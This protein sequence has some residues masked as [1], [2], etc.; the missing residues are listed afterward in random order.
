MNVTK[1][2]VGIDSTG[3]LGAHNF[4]H[5]RQSRIERARITAAGLREIVNDLI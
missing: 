5:G 2:C 1:H 4:L 3:K